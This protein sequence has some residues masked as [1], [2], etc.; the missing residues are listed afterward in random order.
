PKLTGDTGV[1]VPASD[2]ARLSNGDCNT[3]HLEMYFGLTC[4]IHEVAVENTTPLLSFMYI[5]VAVPIWRRLLR[6]FVTLARSRTPLKT[7]TAIAAR[8]LI[9]T[10]TTSNSMSVKARA[11][12]GGEL[13]F[14]G[15]VVRSASY[16]ARKGSESEKEPQGQDCL[17][18]HFPFGVCRSCPTKSLFRLHQVLAPSRGQ[19]LH[20]R[21][22]L[23]T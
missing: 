20:Q 19:N 8:M 12:G 2:P 15:L 4:V 18:R 1:P 17:T 16:C 23:P 14:M 7:G 13:L 9:V 6:S 11:T 5:C 3:A 10:I 22:C 21:V